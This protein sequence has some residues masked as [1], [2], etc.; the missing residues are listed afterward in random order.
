MHPN[1]IFKKKK[2]GVLDDDYMYMNLVLSGIK[3][4]G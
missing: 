1:S 4:I 3:V 2:G